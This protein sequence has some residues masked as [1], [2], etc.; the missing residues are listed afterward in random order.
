MVMGPVLWF[1]KNFVTI[2]KLKIGNFKVTTKVKST[3]S[4]QNIALY[5]FR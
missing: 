5:K 1:T 2:Q 3:N 4:E